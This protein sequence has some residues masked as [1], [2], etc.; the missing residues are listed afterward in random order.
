M[1]ICLVYDHLYPATI[2]GAERWLHGLSLALA[3]AGHEVTYLTMTHWENEPPVLPGVHIVGLTPPGRVYGEERRALLPPLR[4]GWAIARHLARHGS[5]YDVVH[6]ESFPFFPL[7][8]IALLRR[9]HGYAVVVDWLEVWSRPYWRRYAGRIVGTMGWLVQKACVRTRHR[10]LCLSHMHARRLVAEGYR[11]EPIVLPGLYEGPLAPSVATAIEPLVVYAGRHVAEKRVHALVQAFSEV[12]RRRP[13]LRLEI[14]GDGV[15][16][17]RIAATIG[18][19][20]L[21]RVA[22]MMGRRAETEVMAAFG[23]AACLATASE[24]EGY[25][26]IV[27]E[28]AAR[29]TP[30]VVVAGEENAATELVEPG[31]NGEIA[32]SAAPA[33]IAEAIVRVVESG[34]DLRE[35]TVA[36]FASNAGHLRL[37]NSLDVVLG[38]YS[39]V[40]GAV[41]TLTSR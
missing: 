13:D 27:V 21:D 14:Y 8:A 40:G 33:D 18:D 9:R 39:E 24:R 38:V 10:A 22:M 25:G 17:R 32:A 31:V 29:G 36:W 1:R 7:L 6:A 30:S 15:E 19:L 2:G 35:S 4:F 28:A 3:G 5:R 12:S 37:E 20:G 11:G 23:R 26:L 16:S 34:A 41:E